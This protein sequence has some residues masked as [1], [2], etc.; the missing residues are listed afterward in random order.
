MKFQLIK[1]APYSITRM[2]EGKYVNGRWV[3]SAPETFERHLKI[4]PLRPAEVLNFPEAERNRS[5]LQV[6]C[7]EAD[8]RVMQQGVGGHPADRFKYRGFWY[9]IYKEDFHDASACIPHAR[10]VAVREEVTPN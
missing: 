3:E 8:L 7:Q 6:F 5:F 4:Q 2:G 9:E 10:Y 1:F